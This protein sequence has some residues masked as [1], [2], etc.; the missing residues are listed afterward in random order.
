MK[1]DRSLLSL[2]VQHS[3]LM[4][5]AKALIGDVDVDPSLMDLLQFSRVFAQACSGHDL[6][7][8]VRCIPHLQKLGINKN[9]EK[10]SEEKIVL[11][12]SALFIA[13]YY[14]FE[15]IIPHLLKA[16]ANVN[17]SGMISSAD[18]DEEKTQTL[19]A[20]SV[21][22]QRLYV[23]I[24]KLLLKENISTAHVY[25]AEHVTH[26][27]TLCYDLAR[28]YQDITVD[29]ASSKKRRELVQ[30]FAMRV[31]LTNQPSQ[32]RVVPEVDWTIRDNE[33]ILVQAAKYGD[34]VLLAEFLF[35][36]EK[37]VALDRFPHKGAQHVEKVSGWIEFAKA[38]ALKAVFDTFELHPHES[39]VIAKFLRQYNAEF[40]EMLKTQ[41]T[42]SE[43]VETKRELMQALFPRDTQLYVLLNEF[44]QD[45]FKK[46]K[47]IS[48]EKSELK[49][50]FLGG[51][52]KTQLVTESFISQISNLLA[53]VRRLTLKDYLFPKHKSYEKKRSKFKDFQ[54]EF[55]KYLQHYKN[56]LVD[57]KMDDYLSRL[58]EII[59]T[60]AQSSRSERKR[61]S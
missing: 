54:T 52:F 56:S 1:S 39:V 16:G 28:S 58:Q 17:S 45:V 20:I 61:L 33:N 43:L 42:F 23:D 31:R 46:F 57:L 59:E 44:A 48:S 25:H 49:M 11:H 4:P 19:S 3:I 8:A 26:A 22:T 27:R 15:E 35:Y 9:L 41:V 5:E 55:L 37:F 10:I 2:E 60:P 14:G 12:G 30:L 18:G 38:S 24:V 7:Q 6:D 32:V 51:L 50:T 29:E 53:K 13:A 21:A 34:F 40:S 36:F 47:S